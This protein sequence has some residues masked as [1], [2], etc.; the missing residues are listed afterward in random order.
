[1]ID[2]PCV[3]VW[4]YCKNDSEEEEIMM[5]ISLSRIEDEDIRTIE[6]EDELECNYLCSNYEYD[7]PQFFTMQI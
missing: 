4:I 6:F 3:R 2:I 1:M 5:R 7:F